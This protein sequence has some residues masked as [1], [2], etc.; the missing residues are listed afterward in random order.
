MPTDPT[1]IKIPDGVEKIPLPIIIPAMTVMAANRS[2]YIELKARVSGDQLDQYLRKDPLYVVDYLIHR[3]HYFDLL[4]RYSVYCR[5]SE[6][7]FQSFGRIDYDC[8]P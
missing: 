3:N 6:P 5:H 8:R 2:E 4:I 7:I 1:E